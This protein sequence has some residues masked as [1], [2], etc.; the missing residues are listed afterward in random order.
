MN[1]SWLSFLAAIA[2]SQPSMAH[3]L[4]CPQELTW[5]DATYAERSTVDSKGRLIR[6]SVESFSNA[7]LI[8]V[9]ET[10]FKAR[11]LRMKNA[12]AAISLTFGADRPK[13]IDFAEIA[14]AVE[15]PM[16]DGSW[17]RMKRPCDIKDGSVIAFSEK[18]MR[19]EA[20]ANPV[21]S[22]RF[23]GVLRREGLSFSYVITVEAGGAE[24]GFSYKGQLRY[25]LHDKAFNL[26]TDMRG[27]HVYRADTFVKTL[28]MG[29]RVPLSAVLD[30]AKV[31]SQR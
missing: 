7:G 16:G 8:E 14:M 29:V 19:G 4:L 9:D 27:W 1:T 21:N 2:I 15:P 31:S 3:G 30:E 20:D 26:A 18:D 5:G 13:P 6:A 11:L 28:P 25:G 23:H 10:S 12:E 17:S 22:V 24:P